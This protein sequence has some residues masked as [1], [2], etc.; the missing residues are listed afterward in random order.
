MKKL[1]LLMLSVMLA[2][3]PLTS[4]AV[5]KVNSGADRPSVTAAED[6]P[7]NKFGKEHKLD[8]AES[9][10]VYTAPSTQAV[11]GA[12]GKATMGTGGTI[13]SAGWNNQWLLIRY[14][15]TKGGYRVGWVRKS[16]FC[17]QNQENLEC[18]RNVKFAYWTV[19]AK[20][21]S[22]LTDDPI[23]ESEWLGTV[24]QGEELTFLSYYQYDAGHTKYAYVQG[25]MDGQPIAGFIPFDAIEW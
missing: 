20:E 21:D 22:Y 23:E 7:L 17:D 5:M 10:K 8:V 13:Y 12:D 9:I 4:F 15:K 3:L 25:D 24:A 2:A 1:V 18:T 11:R 19:R 16:D 6:Y 14:E